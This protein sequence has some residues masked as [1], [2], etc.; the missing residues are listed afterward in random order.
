M[1]DLACGT[2]RHAIAAARR[3]AV[4]EGIDWSS[5]RLSIAEERARRAG[6]TVQW[7]GENLETFEIPEYAYDVVMAFNYLD[8]RRFPDM[9]RA[10][11]PGGYLLYETFHVEQGRFG[12]GPTSADHLLEPAELLRLVRP[13]VVEFSREVIETIDTRSAALASVVARRPVQ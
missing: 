12:W 5:E 11:K 7:K 10:V 13:L 4:V 1:L 8:R 3:G 6:I 9:V 2:G